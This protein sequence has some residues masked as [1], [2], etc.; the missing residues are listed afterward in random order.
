MHSVVYEVAARFTDQSTAD[1]WVAWMLTEHIADVVRAGAERGRV[2]RLDE[3]PLCYVAQYEFSTAE[4][5]TNYLSQHAPRLRAEGLK[6]FSPDRVQ[7]T[8]RTGVV[9]GP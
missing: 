8:R 7:Y 2:I 6:R 5:L 9:V 1:A 3:T 4:A